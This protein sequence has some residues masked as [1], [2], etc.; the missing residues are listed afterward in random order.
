[1]K[2]ATIRRYEDGDSVEDSRGQTQD[3]APQSNLLV[4]AALSATPNGVAF[5][6]ERGDD[7][8][9]WLKMYDPMRSMT[10]VSEM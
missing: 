1:M 8:H 4:G 2:A 5:T 10:T 6:G 3:I 9:E 7:E